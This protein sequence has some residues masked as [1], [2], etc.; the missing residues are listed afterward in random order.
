MALETPRTAPSLC[1]LRSRSRCAYSSGCGRTISRAQDAQLQYSWAL[2]LAKGSY[3]AHGQLHAAL[4][5]KREYRVDTDDA[6]LA[7]WRGAVA[8]LAPQGLQRKIFRR[9]VFSVQ[10]AVPARA[11]WGPFSWRVCDRPAATARVCRV[12]I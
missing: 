1:A 2:V 5:H 6:A 4:G 9:R 12:P 3:A 8:A 7:A 11:A 10:A